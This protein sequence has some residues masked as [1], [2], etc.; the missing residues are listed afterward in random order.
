[1]DRRHHLFPLDRD[2]EFNLYGYDVKSKGMR[3]LTAF[4][5]FP[6]L[7]AAA[8]GSGIIL[9]QAGY[10]HTL[11]IASGN[12]K[13]LVIGVAADLAASRPHFGQGHEV[14][15]RHLR[16]AHRR[17]RARWNFRGEIVTVP[18]EKGDV[19]NLTNTVAANERS[20]DLVAGRQIDR[21]FFPM[22]PVN[23]NCMYAPRTAKGPRKNTPCT[24]PA[25]TTARP[26]RPTARRFSTP[27]I[28]SAFM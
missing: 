13:R 1:V 14:R 25:I 22:S 28:A 8:F 6:V 5:D 17:R 3:I 18:A 26:G 21:L 7:N 19:R 4:K 20:P 23:T 9:E 11:D 12:T 24:A 16:L 10:L 27:T 2:G 15:P